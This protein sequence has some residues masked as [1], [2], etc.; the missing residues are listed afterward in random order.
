[1]QLETSLQTVIEELV[2]GNHILYDQNVFDCYGHLSAR[3]PADPEKFLLSWAIAPG[4]VA[5]DDILTYDLAGKPLNDRGKEQFSERFIHSEIYAARPDVMGVVHSHSS[6]IIPFT[7]VDEPLRP[8]WHVSSFLSGGVPTFDPQPAMGDTDL[9]VRTSEL[10]KALVQTLGDG[11]AVLMRGHGSAVVGRNVREAVYRAVY[12]E[13]NARIQSEAARFGKPI[14][15]LSTGE[16]ALMDKWLN[17]DVRR[18]WE[19]WCDEAK[20]KRRNA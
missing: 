8:V 6:A 16:A 5:A 7:I 15:F 19:L 14:K 13:T 12:T 3:H 1:M 10:G 20:A 9:L 2:L 18:P 4:I 11:I 17:P